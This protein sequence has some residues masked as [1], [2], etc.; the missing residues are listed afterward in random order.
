M[1][2][3]DGDVTLRSAPLRLQARGGMFLEQRF[4]VVCTDDFLLL[5]GQQSDPVQHPVP[6]SRPT[7][8]EQLIDMASVSHSQEGGAAT[9][10]GADAMDGSE[11]P[12]DDIRK[13]DAIMPDDMSMQELDDDMDVHGM[14]F[15]DNLPSTFHQALTPVTMGP[16][17]G[18][19]GSSAQQNSACGGAYDLYYSPPA[20]FEQTMRSFLRDVPFEA[21]DIWVPMTDS[22]GRLWLQF[23]GG[24]AMRPD[25]YDWV[26]YSRAFCFYEGEGMPGRVFRSQQTEYQDDIALLDRNLFLR[27]VRCIFGEFS[28]CLA[29]EEH[30]CT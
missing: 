1:G 6:V 17:R 22:G 10:A 23:G 16:Q 28:V 8:T 2:V 5:H 14:D 19:A 9:A 13:I 30:R 24:L 27:R 3:T 20:S 29:A 15:L 7:P 4:V 11:I 25:L 18:G 12:L 21:V 26:Y